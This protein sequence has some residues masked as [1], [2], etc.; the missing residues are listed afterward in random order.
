MTEISLGLRL[1]VGPDPLERQLGRAFTAPH[2]VYP[3][4]PGT[5][6]AIGRGA[7]LRSRTHYV[8][9][10]HPRANHT[11]DHTALTTHA[12]HATHKQETP[13]NY[14]H[15]KVHTATAKN[16]GTQQRMSRCKHSVAPHPTPPTPAPYS[17]E[18]DIG[19]G[20]GRGQQCQRGDAA[21]GLEMGRRNMS[22]LGAGCHRAL[23][24]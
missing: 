1:Y 12:E 17:S 14:Q 2:K 4:G 19:C 20:T 24:D 16:T 13:T 23:V 5:T 18:E 22:D 9:L 3:R 6:S 8:H 7:K 11:A 15:T 21:A 10:T